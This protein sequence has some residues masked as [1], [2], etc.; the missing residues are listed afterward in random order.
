MAY[1]PTWVGD[2][3]IIL[4]SCSSFESKDFMRLDALSFRFHLSIIQSENKYCFGLVDCYRESL[5]AFFEDD[6]TTRRSTATNS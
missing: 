5:R 6:N 4:N 2:K 3:V 1:L